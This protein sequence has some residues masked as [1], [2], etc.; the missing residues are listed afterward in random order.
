MLQQTVASTGKEPTLLQLADAW[1]KGSKEAS[2][3]RVCLPRGV[4][5]APNTAPGAWDP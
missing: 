1:K 3:S 4:E 5:R 2:R